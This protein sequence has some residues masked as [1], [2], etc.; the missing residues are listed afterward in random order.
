MKQI[1][2]K[3]RQGQFIGLHA[4]IAGNELL[5]NKFKVHAAGG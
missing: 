3:R 4:L 2:S 1:D 5:Q